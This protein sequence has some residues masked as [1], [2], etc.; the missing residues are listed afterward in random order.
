MYAKLSHK[1]VHHHLGACIKTESTVKVVVGR[2]LSPSVVLMTRWSAGKIA[3][4][5]GVVSWLISPFFF[6][7]S[8]QQPTHLTREPAR[9]PVVSILFCLFFYPSHERQKTAQ[10]EYR[11]LPVATTVA[12]IT[13][14]TTGV[15]TKVLRQK[16]QE[17][18]VG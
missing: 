13:T 18:K 2:H 10:R 14:I 5:F 6:D 9:P 16:R 17:E 3:S 12:P 15:T 11:S 8:A 7:R 4:L 1:N